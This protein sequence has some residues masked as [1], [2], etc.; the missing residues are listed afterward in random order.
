MKLYQITGKAG[1]PAAAQKIVTHVLRKIRGPYH[2]AELAQ[3]AIDSWPNSRE[4]GM[5]CVVE[6]RS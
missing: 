1:L 5:L 4:R 6:C 2:M 3:L